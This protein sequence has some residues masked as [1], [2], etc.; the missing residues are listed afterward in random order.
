MPCGSILC[1]KGIKY[2]H[3]KTLK[4]ETK[5]KKHMFLKQKTYV[6]HSKFICFFKKI[7]MFFFSVFRKEIFKVRIKQ[8]FC[9]Y[10]ILS[11]LLF[12]ISNGSLPKDFRNCP[13]CI[14]LWLLSSESSLYINESSKPP[15]AASF[16]SA[17]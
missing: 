10:R 14:A 11:C 9:Q 17:A 12:Q 15:S 5:I 7:H 16:W 2:L 13:L 8:R 6:F 1:R 4:S 3:C